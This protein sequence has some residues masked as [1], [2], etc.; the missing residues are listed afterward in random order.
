M[1]YTIYTQNYCPSCD[2]LKVNLED[3]GIIVQYVNVD[4]FPNK[5]PEDL[6]ITPALSKGNSLIAYGMDIL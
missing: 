5:K 1:E 6:F 2:I 4:E 3:L